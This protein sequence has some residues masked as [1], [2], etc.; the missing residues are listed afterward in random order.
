MY[1]QVTAYA[2]DLRTGVVERVVGLIVVP[3]GVVAKLSITGT[4]LGTIGVG[5]P[6]ELGAV[7]DLLESLP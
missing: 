7:L 4:A 1:E 2:N 6:R 3:E 5:P